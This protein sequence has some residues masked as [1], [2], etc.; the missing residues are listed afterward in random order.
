MEKTKSMSLHQQAR[1]L[2]PTKLKNGPMTLLR[3][4]K[5]AR[6]SRQQSFEGVRN[7]AF[8]CLY[9]ELGEL[10]L[11]EI[12][13]GSKSSTNQVRVEF[14]SGLKYRVPNCAGEL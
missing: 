7:E 6:P 8:S 9:N 12:P 11:D 1:Y 5:K 4:T 14:N 13:F 10:I 2:T 3:S